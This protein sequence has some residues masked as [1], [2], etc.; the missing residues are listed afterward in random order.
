MVVALLAIWIAFH[1]LSHGGLPDRPEPVEP[2]G[3]EHLDRRSWRRGWCSSSCRATSTCRSA[4]CSAS[5]ATRWRWSRPT[6][7]SPSSASTS[8]SHGLAGQGVRL[9]RRARLRPPARRRSSASLQGFLV[10]YVG[11]PVVHRHARRLPR[12]AR[13]SSS[14]S[15][16]KQGQ[17]LAPLDADVPAARRR[18][19]GLARRV[20]ELARR[21]ARLRGHR[22]QPR[23]RPPA[24][25]ALRARRAP[26]VGRDRARRARLRGRASPAS[27]WSPTATTRPITGKPT[28]HRLP[29]RDPDRRH[30]ADDLPGPAPALRPL[31]VRLR[32]QPR[33]RRARRHQHPA[34]RHDDVRRSWVCC[35]P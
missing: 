24:P 33:G 3:P 17:T 2:V 15:G 26:D 29:G 28:G 9:D 14:A 30:A 25:P 13:R 20:E 5:S 1:I 23:A 6:G 16:G 19:E 35:A 18:G 32:R 12:L 34:H 27:G 8:P 7:S 22:A 31:R 10:A 4:R 11:V 21:A